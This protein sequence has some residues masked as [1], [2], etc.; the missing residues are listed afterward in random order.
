MLCTEPESLGDVQ[1]ER[2]SLGGQADGRKGEQLETSL[3][4]LSD[5]MMGK[6]W[7]GEQNPLERAQVSEEED[8][9][10]FKRECLALK[11]PSSCK[12][13]EAPGVHHPV[14]PETAANDILRPDQ[15]RFFSS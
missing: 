12:G 10:A 4:V 3:A 11:S 13:M 14:T 8:K 7:D 1:T 15:E 2:A 5:D 6:H 9:V